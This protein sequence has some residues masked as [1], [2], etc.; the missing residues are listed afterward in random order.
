MSKTI[1]LAGAT[2]LVGSACLPLLLADERVGKVAALVRRPLDLQHPKLEQWIAPG[3]DLL[4]G[5]KPEPVDAVICGL[6]T[7][8]KKAGS[9]AAFIAVDKDLPLGIARWAKAQG[10][11]TY[12][13]I[14]AIGAD[15]GSRVFYSR[16]KGEVE[17]E[18][19]AMHFG[20][21]ALFQPSILTGP[22]KEKRF[23][24]HIGIAVTKAVGP[25]LLGPM[26]SYRVMPHDVLAKA[27]VNT[28][29]SPAPGTK[30]YTYSGILRQAGI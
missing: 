9:Q 5:L 8:I 14:S 13:I 16:V 6:G 1:L 17:Q 7:T 26:K 12:A 27:L 2:G 3:N 22:R 21:L 28:A 11:L 30:R 19:E 25:V 10:V 15:P 23:G 24:E 29:L 4:Q 18:L 20:S